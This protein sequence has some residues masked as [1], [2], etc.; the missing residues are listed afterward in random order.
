MP[1]INAALPFGTT[2]H[3]GKYRLE[4][5]LGQGGFAITYRA[6]L[7]TTGQVVAIKE[8][9]PEDIAHRQA[10]GSIHIANDNKKAF[11]DLIEHTRREQSV[12]DQIKHS[13][14]TFTVESWAERNTVYLAMEYLD[15]ETLEKRI[16]RGDLLSSDQAIAVLRALLPLLQQV[17]ILGF[18]HRDIKPANIILSSHGPELIDFGS[19]T[20]FTFGQRIKVTSRFLTPAYAPLEQYGQEVMIGPSTDLYAL[21]ATL[22]EA[23][24]GV[25]VPSALDRANGVPLTPIAALKHDVDRQLAQVLERTLE[26]R[27]DQRPRSV[28]EMWR[29]T[30]RQI[31]MRTVSESKT[32]IPKVRYAYQT[33]ASLQRWS[34][35]TAFC[36]LFIVL[37]AFFWSNFAAPTSK[38]PTLQ[39]PRVSS[40]PLPQS[41]KQNPFFNNAS[42][43]KTSLAVKSERPDFYLLPIDDVAFEQLE[44]IRPKLERRLKLRITVLA[45]AHISSDSFDT[46][47]QQYI[48]EEL[49]SQVENVRQKYAGAFILGVTSDDLFIRQFK[50]NWAFGMYEPETGNAVLSSARMNPANAGLPANQ[51][52]LEAR[53]RKMIMKY[54]GLL[55]LKNLRTPSI[56]K[57]YFTVASPVFLILTPVKNVSNP[58]GSILV[59]LS[60]NRSVNSYGLYTRKAFG[61][62]LASSVRLG[63]SNS[64]SMCAAVRSNHSTRTVRPRKT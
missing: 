7:V 17:H 27:V 48:A 47:R 30:T 5:A 8:L 19:V 26:L 46:N 11:E 58:N 52:L 57:A 56:P 12:L 50:W 35:A 43:T 36:L 33:P 54:V 64:P 32:S 61:T 37:G 41:Q 45:C 14:T 23:L 51:M 2:L 49:T 21:A 60:R 55:Y 13:A 9:F 40:T 16:A 34:P 39:Q 25:R 15:G 1:V 44:M 10:D 31:T 4:G 29:L 63:S 42:C 18:V 22:Y 24:T 20:A 28:M 53:L 59:G 3:G 38:N 6:V 62:M